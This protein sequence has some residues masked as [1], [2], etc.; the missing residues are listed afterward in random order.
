MTPQQDLNLGPVVLV[1]VF[2]CVLVV[3]CQVEASFWHQIE[4]NDHK[5]P[6]I[7]NVKLSFAELADTDFRQNSVGEYLMF[8]SI[9]Y[10]SHYIFTVQVQISLIKLLRGCVRHTLAYSFNVI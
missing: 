6:G 8:L 3:D 1:E 5:R 9:Y 7:K 2:G 10:C 4:I